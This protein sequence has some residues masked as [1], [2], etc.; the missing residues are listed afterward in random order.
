VSRGV[1][2]RN[3]GNNHTKSPYGDWG[4]SKAY[5]VG[6][7]FLAA[8][9]ASFPIILAVCAL[10]GLVGI[11]YIVICRHFPDSSGGVVHDHSRH[12]FPLASVPWARARS[13][14]RSGAK[15]L[16]PNPRPFVTVRAAAEPC[17]LDSGSG[18]FLWKSGKIGVVE[19]T[20]QVLAGA[21]TAADNALKDELKGHVVKEIGALARPE[22][23]R[24]T[25]ALPK[26]RSGKI[27]RRLLRELATSGTVVGDTTTLEDF[28]VIARLRE[29][30]E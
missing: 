3:R 27:M 26:T 24:F 22:E 10:T 18:V 11:N 1:R 21:G 2:V 29:D 23:I 9:F 17:G 12:R 4:T 14:A 30:E 6:L 25:D 13:N 19:L 8:G 7:A 20:G 16:A 15:S 5:V 28:S